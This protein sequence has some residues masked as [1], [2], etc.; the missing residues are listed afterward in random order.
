MNEK[1]K[2][3]AISGVLNKDEYIK[4]IKELDDMISLVRYERIGLRQ[5]IK[6]A[7][8]IFDYCKTPQQRQQLSKTHAKYDKHNL[9]TRELHILALI[10]EFKT[11]KEVA[12]ECFVSQRCVKFHRTNIFKKLGVKTLNEFY[13]LD[14]G[15]L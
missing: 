8:Q 14:S 9:T 11:S 7:D 13:R 12:D 6:L 2:N 4:R 5:K 15:I 1:T 10:A 3:D